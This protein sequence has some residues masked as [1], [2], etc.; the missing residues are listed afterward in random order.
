M[1][2]DPPARDQRRI[3]AGRFG[4]NL[5]GLAARLFVFLA[6]FFLLVTSREPPW[7]DAHVTYD[8]TEALVD[9]GALDTTLEGG[10]T[11]FYAHRNGKKYGVFPLGNVVAMV[12]SYL[13][14]KLVHRLIPSIPDRPLYC[15][16]SHLSPSLL[17]AAACALFFKLCRQRTSERWAFFATLALGLTTFCLIYARSPYSEALQTLALMW[18]V[19]RA[20]TQAERPT[21]QGMGWLAV[22]AGILINAK[23]VNVMLLLPVAAYVLW[24]RHRAGALAEVLRTLPLV[25]FIFGE[26]VAIALWHN[27]M[28][29]GSLVTTGYQIKDG[30]FSG[31]LFSALHGFFLSPGKSFFLYS[32]PAVLG[33]CGLAVAFSRRRLETVFLGSVVLISLLF[34]AKFRHWH[35][36][37]CWGPRHLVPVTPIIMLWAFP[38]LPE[39]LQRGHTQLRR[40]AVSALLAAGLFVNFLGASV[41]WDHYIRVLIAMKDQSAANGW[42]QEDLSH[43]HYIP[44]FSPLQGHWWML[45]HMKNRDPDMYRDAPWKLIMPI[46][47]SVDEAKNRMRPDWWMLEVYEDARGKVPAF[48][49]LSVLSSS[50]IFAGVLL[51]WALRRADRTFPDGAFIDGGAV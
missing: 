17:M 36:D 45:R 38:W 39:A 25:F 47:V 1:L 33:F 37:Y 16:F 2:P 6:L 30:I 15:F 23:L 18:V 24:K 48:I 13:S 35:A 26:F 5:P 49:M 11:W 4:V 41:Y 40:L 19:E 9:R 29:T 44:G 14:Y 7:A 28:K 51:V 32:P 8:T 27:H 42:Y 10:P 34:N 12:P 20:L 22:A 46:P 31:D 21:L 50:T 43:G 3:R